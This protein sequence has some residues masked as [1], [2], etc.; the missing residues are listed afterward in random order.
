M[1]LLDLI[2]I[3]NIPSGSGSKRKKQMKEMEREERRKDVSFTFIPNQK[4][5]QNRDTNDWI[6][7]SSMTQQI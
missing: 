3:R 6:V 7:P 5:A 2:R 1:L 4:F